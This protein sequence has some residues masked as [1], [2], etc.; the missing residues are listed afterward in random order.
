MYFWYILEHYA[1]VFRQHKETGLYVGVENN[2]LVV[3]ELQDAA[4]DATS[5]ESF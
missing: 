3:K 1:F 5:C 4:K 2:Q